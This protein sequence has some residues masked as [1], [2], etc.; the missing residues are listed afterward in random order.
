M[1]KNGSSFCLF[2]RRKRNLKDYFQARNNDGNPLPACLPANRGR[3]TVS[4]GNLMPAAQTRPRK[5]HRISSHMTPSRSSPPQL[6]MPVTHGKSLSQ[7]RSWTDLFSLLIEISP[8]LLLSE[9]SVPASCSSRQSTDLGF[10]QMLGSNQ[11]RLDSR[12]NTNKEGDIKLPQI[13]Y[14]F[15]SRHFV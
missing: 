8:I 14:P 4:V 10:E 1:K 7:I 2:R 15:V 6:A 5:R 13:P 12:K 3:G 9:T 11:C